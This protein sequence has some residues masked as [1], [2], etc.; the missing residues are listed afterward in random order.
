VVSPTGTTIALATPRCPARRIYTTRP[1]MQHGVHYVCGRLMRWQH[2]AAAWVCR[3]PDCA[4]VYVAR[5]WE[6]AA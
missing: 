4:A 6:A 1:T 5:E 2:D 3:D